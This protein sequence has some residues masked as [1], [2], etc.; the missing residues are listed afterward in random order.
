[1]PLYS[2]NVLT[3]FFL[4]FFINQKKPSDLFLLQHFP[5]SGLEVLTQRRVQVQCYKVVV[6]QKRVQDFFL[7]WAELIFK[8]G[9]NYFDH[10]QK[11]TISN[12]IRG[13]FRG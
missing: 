7:L 8:G 12:F 5:G 11:H 1:M 9:Q 13:I 10:G 4:L 6:T 3:I 2:E